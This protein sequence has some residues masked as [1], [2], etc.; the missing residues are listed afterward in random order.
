MADSQG[1]FD[2]LAG[3][4][5]RPINRPGLEAFVANS[6]SQNG[7]RSAQTEA[8]LVNA[9]RSREE[10]QASGELENSFV[11][12]GMKPSEAHMA[13][14]IAKGHFGT[15]LEAMKAIGDQQQNS[16]RTTLGDPNQLGSPTQTAAQQGVQG[17]V[18][19]PTALPDN[20][21]TLPGSAPVQAAQS[22]EG[23]A[24][25]A[26]TGAQTAATTSLGNLHQTQSDAGGFNP[27]TNGMASLPPEQ[28]AALNAAMA[29]GGLDPTRINSR[30]ASILGQMALANPDFNFNRMHADAALQSNGGFQ[31]KAMTMEAMPTILQ[32]MTTLGKKI[33]YSDN[34]TV[35][36]MQAF[37]NGEFNDPDYT[38][39]MS[40]RNDSLMKIASVMRGVGMSDQAHTAEIEAAAPTL[41]PLA[42]DGWL[43]G[44]MSSLQPLLDQQRR[45]TQLGDTNGVHPTLVGGGGSAPAPAAGGFTEGQTAVNKA[46]GQ[47][48]VFKGGQWQPAQ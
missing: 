3:A 27:H 24:K 46:T 11:S 36:K 15:A 7:L 45:V 30:N 4:A 48:L 29:R 18:A 25:T 40:V 17:K 1:L 10:Q 2:S 6:Q 42:L 9:Q 23:A 44:Q 26:L 41:S 33:G 39:Y 28:Q 35:G 22:V 32:H 13:A 5:G 20:Y 21:T 8:A 31:Q 14:T 38:E 37:M 19:E 43:K 16:F 12:N 34:K 47:R